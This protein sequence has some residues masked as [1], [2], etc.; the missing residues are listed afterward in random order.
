MLPATSSQLNTELS[1]V[2]CED[3]EGW[4]GVGGRETQGAGGICT[5]IA[6]SHRS[7]AK[8]TQQYKAVILLKKNKSS[9]L[10]PSLRLLGKCLTLAWGCILRASDAV[11]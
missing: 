5:H 3:L 9:Q 11:C 10:K 6:D 2:L 8:L 7:T 1:S 4:D